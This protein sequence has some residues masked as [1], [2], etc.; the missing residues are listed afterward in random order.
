MSCWTVYL[1]LETGRN[2]RKKQ[3]TIKEQKTEQSRDKNW[4][5]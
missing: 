5:I 3:K 4:T 2:D 1:L